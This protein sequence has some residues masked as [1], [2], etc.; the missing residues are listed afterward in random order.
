MQEGRKCTEQESM[1]V[2]R[3]RDI[4]KNSYLILESELHNSL[5]ATIQAVENHGKQVR[6]LR[7]AFLNISYILNMILLF[8][9]VVIGKWIFIG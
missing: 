1:E 4:S 5:A 7:D 8:I 3:N 9:L 2:S 6:H